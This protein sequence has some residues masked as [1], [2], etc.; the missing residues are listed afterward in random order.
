MVDLQK[1]HLVFTFI[2]SFELSL[3]SL[4]RS[5]YYPKNLINVPLK[6]IKNF[7]HGVFRKSTTII[8]NVFDICRFQKYYDK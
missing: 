1:K 3:T 6:K 2:V 4:S 5:L 8:D 7:L